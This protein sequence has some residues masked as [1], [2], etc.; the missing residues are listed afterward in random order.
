MI[1]IYPFFC[2]SLNVLVKSS[3]SGSSFVTTM[4]NKNGNSPVWIIADQYSLY[5]SVGTGHG[6]IWTALFFLPLEVRE[7]D[8][9]PSVLAY[10]YSATWHT[11]KRHHEDLDLKSTLG[12]HPRKS[13]FQVMAAVCSDR[14]WITYGCLDCLFLRQMNIKKKKM[15]QA[16]QA[17]LERHPTGSVLRS[18]WLLLSGGHIQIL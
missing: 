6:F 2:L 15:H 14:C 9:F 13:T 10:S 8:T 12:G 1:E 16:I 3:A 4:A 7:A 11:D 17:L 18:L 5:S